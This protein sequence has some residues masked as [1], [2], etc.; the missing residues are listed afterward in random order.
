ML[1]MSEKLIKSKED[2]DNRLNKGAYTLEGDSSIIVKTIPWG[3]SLI[4]AN[5]PTV[6]SKS[7][8]IR[9]TL[10]S[11]EKLVEIAKYTKAKRASEDAVDEMVEATRMLT[12]SIREDEGNF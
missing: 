2:L 6:T 4:I 7:D 5:N 9:L 1:T 3:A 11:L 10:E 12:P 8:T